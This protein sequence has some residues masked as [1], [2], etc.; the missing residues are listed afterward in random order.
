MC[1][2]PTP[3]ATP[4]IVEV[5]EDG[6]LDPRLETISVKSPEMVGVQQN[7]HKKLLKVIDVEKKI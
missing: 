1:L 5:E 4:E 6:K 7:K 3:Y 2:K